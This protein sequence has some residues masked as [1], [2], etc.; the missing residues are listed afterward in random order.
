VL[1][2][3]QLPADNPVKKSAL[4]YVAKYEA[5]H[6]KGSVTA[7]GGYAWDAGQFAGQ[8]RPCR[9]EEGAARAEGVPHGA[10]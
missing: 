4:E 6:G 10:A 3:A 7:F 1:V 5:V 2:A 8:C 9:A